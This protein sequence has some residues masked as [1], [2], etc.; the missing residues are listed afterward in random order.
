MI[1]P[2]DQ[3]SP[4]ADSRRTASW[5]LVM[6]LAAATLT[7]ALLPSSGAPYFACPFH[8]LTG[9][10]CPFCGYTR[11][12]IALTHGRPMDALALAPLIPPLFAAAWALGLAALF[13]PAFRGPLPRLDFLHRK[14]FWTV[15]AGLWLL[16]WAYRLAATMG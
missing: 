15:L 8:A 12:L 11:S 2:G 6:I 5:A 9:A 4:Q 10:P 3:T 16:D 13:A 14:W 1:T 7:A